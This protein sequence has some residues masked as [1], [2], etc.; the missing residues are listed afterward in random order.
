M[1]HSVRAGDPSTMYELGDY[2]SDCGGHLRGDEHD[3]RGESCVAA[4][5]DM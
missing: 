3:L 4:I 2:R 5:V 1:P